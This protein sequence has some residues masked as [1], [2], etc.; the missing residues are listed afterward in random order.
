[1]TIYM[2][3]GSA[4]QNKELAQKQTY[5]NNMMQNKY[6]KWLEFAI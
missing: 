2:L 5:Y 3:G 4:K 1:M 6:I